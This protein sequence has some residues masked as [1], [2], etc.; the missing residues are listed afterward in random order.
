[1]D[2]RFLTTRRNVLAGMTAVAGSLTLGRSAFAML[3][4]AAK[5][6][7]FIAS[8]T[9]RLTPFPMTQVRLLDGLVKRRLRSTRRISIR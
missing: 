4:T 5:T 6:D 1:M 9:G 8:K 2:A 7:D 3:D